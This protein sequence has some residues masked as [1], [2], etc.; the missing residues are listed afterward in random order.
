MRK[1]GFTL[2]EVLAVV[3]II[4][5]LGAL[6]I[7][8]VNKDV[9]RSRETLY[10]QQVRSIEDA[11]KDWAASH[12]GILPT[13]TSDAALVVTLGDLIDEGFFA[14]DIIN[15]KTK[16]AFSRDT[17]ITITYTSQNKLKYVITVKE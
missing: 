9:S 13:S 2:I 6:I 15:P 4:A 7:P 1:N 12:L 11:A 3:A 8:I 5:L 16:K 14:D 10:E 17:S